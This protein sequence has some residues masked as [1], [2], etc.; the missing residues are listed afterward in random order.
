MRYTACASLRR[1]PRNSTRCEPAA[2]REVRSVALPARTERS[3]LS[4]PTRSVTSSR[5]WPADARDVEAAEELAAQH[6][7]APA[8]RS[9]Q[10]PALQQREQAHLDSPGVDRL[11][12]Y[13]HRAQ[14]RERP[15]EPCL[16]RRGS[17]VH[18][19]PS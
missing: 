5:S 4:M 6:D 2:P 13:Q 10:E 15:L 8:G 14:L 3:A 11:T 16:V 9:D 19:D 12:G 1:N 7:E 18:V 17:I